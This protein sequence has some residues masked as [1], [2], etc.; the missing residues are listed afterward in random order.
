MQ[1]A[2]MDMQ[3]FIL[4]FQADNGKECIIYI[5]QPS[6]AELR[7]IA[8]VLGFLL[9]KIQGNELNLMVFIQDWEIMLDK[10]YKQQE[11]DGEDVNAIKA[12]L[13]RFL[14]AK[15]SVGNCFNLDGTLF[16]GELSEDEITFITGELLF[17]CCLYRYVKVAFRQKEMRDL[18]TSLT[19]LEYQEL[20]K[21]RHAER[22]VTAEKAKQ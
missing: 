21:K 5:K 22:L 11:K 1:T 10:Y 16:N 9:P 13:A 8:G 7:T 2:K 12:E 19:S 17:F 3:N 6:P 14:N 20:L 18:T 15:I 4:P